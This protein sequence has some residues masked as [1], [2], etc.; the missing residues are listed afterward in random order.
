[1]TRPYPIHRKCREIADSGI[2]PYYRLLLPN[3]QSDNEAG[4]L[5]NIDY[6]IAAFLHPHISTIPRHE[7]KAIP[8]SHGWKGGTRCQ[9]LTG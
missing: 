1:M 2:C 8:Y 3:P 9:T 4:T 5:Q 7:E 6:E